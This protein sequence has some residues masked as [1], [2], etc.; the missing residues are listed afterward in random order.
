MLIFLVSGACSS[1]S[2][3]DQEDVATRFLLGGWVIPK[4]EE[5]EVDAFAERLEAFVI[6]SED[7]M[8]SFLDGL[9]LF[10]V[11]GNLQSL[12]R[13]DFSKVVVVGAYYLWRPLKGD[14]LSIRTMALN[15]DEANIDLELEE[16]PLGREYPYLLAPMNVAAVQKQDLPQG[17]PVKFVFRVNGEAAVTIVNTLE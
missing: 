17:V 11:R 3:S 8:R 16:E 12:H 7:E 4:S 6:T 2:G 10:R 15:G 14:P 5:G 9:Y 13:S 1:S